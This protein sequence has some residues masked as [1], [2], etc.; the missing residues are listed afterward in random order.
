MYE[1][2]ASCLLT[3][4]YTYHIYTHTYMYIYIYKILCIYIQEYL[5]KVNLASREPL[6]ILFPLKPD[7]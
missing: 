3:A 5:A 2:T 7:G 4:F 1:S 6:V